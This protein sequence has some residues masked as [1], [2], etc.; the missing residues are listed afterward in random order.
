MLEWP[1][2]HNKQIAM[3]LLHDTARYTDDDQLVKANGNHHNMAFFMKPVQ[4]QENFILVI[5]FHS[6]HNFLIQKFRV[7]WYVS[8]EGESD[9]SAAKN[10]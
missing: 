6:F 1:A 5:F 2:F 4:N 9:I 7:I 8:E 10:I 3:A